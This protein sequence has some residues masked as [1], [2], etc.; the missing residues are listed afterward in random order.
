MFT[1]GNFGGVEFVPPQIQVRGAGE[2]G[3]RLSP[4]VD[5]LARYNDVVPIV[6]G[7]AWYEPPLVF[8]RNDGNLTV[9]EVLLGMGE[10]DEAVKVVVNDIEIPEGVAGADMTATGWYSVVTPGSRS[11]AFNPDFRDGSGNPLGDPYGSMA[12]ASVVVPNRI[13]SGQTVPRIKVLARGVKLERFDVAGASLGETYANN[14]AWVLLD[15]LRRSG[16]LVSEIDTKSFATTAAYCDELISTTDLYGNSIVVPRFQCNTVIRNRT[17]AGAVVRGIRAGSALQLIYGADGLLKLRVENTIAL[18][19]AEKP[20]GS[21]STDEL[22]GGWPA[23]EFSDGS[24]TFSG[25]LRKS[26][27]EPSIRLY[28]RGP[29]DAP[30]RVTV[31]FQDQFN[32]YQQDSLSLVDV[33]DALLTNQEVSGGFQALGIPNYDQATRMLE[34]QLAKSI[35]GSTFIDLETTVRGVELK[36][37]DIITLTYLKEGLDRQALRIVRLV[38]ATNYASVLITAQWHNDAW[39]TSEGADAHGGR[40]RGRSEIGIPR[41]LKGTV[42]DS[43]GNEQFGIVEEA[44][45]TSDGGLSVELNVSFTPPATPSAIASSIPLVSLNPTISSTGGSLQGGVNWYYAVSARDAAGGET[46]L[47]FS[48]KAKIPTAT[49]TNTVTLTGL[50]FSADAVGMNVY[51]GLNPTQF[52]LVS[53]N[54]AVSSTFTDTGLTSELKSPPDGNYDHAVF[55]WRLELQPEV[56][57]TFHSE[58]TI[59]SS[60]LAMLVNE[61]QGAL[62]TITRG[63]GARQERVVVS[64]TTTT[65]TVTPAWLIEPDA[66]SFFVVNENT[67]NAGGESIL[68]PVKLA[69]PPRPGATVQI[70]GRSAN[71]LKQESTYELNPLTR[72]EIGTTLTGID[73][74]IPPPPVYGL[75]P[76]GNGSIS[77]SSLGFTSFTNTRTIDAGTLVL[78]YW[79]ELLSPSTF[80]LNADVDSAATILDLSSA[81]PAITGI[82]LQIG[83][84]ILEVVDPLSGG[85]QYEVIRGSHGSTAAMHLAGSVIYHLKRTIRVLPFPRGFFGSPAS[86][87][88]S[89]AMFLPDVRV[90]ASELFMTNQFGDGL[91]TQAAYTAT[92]D[93]GIRTLSGGQ[94]S[95]DIEG[96]LAVQTAAA[97]AISVDANHSVRD[98]FA[99]VAEAPVGG[100]IEL[101][102]RQDATVYCTL[103][104]PEHATVSTP[105]VD[106]FGLAPLAEGVQLIL[107]ITAVPGVAN[108]LPGRDLTVTIRF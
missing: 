33:D 19:Q 97:P 41:P 93:Q 73:S 43:N 92:T 64:N 105:S 96:Y 38:P 45:P 101:S 99:Q 72:W 47:S 83:A 69:A 89:Q 87:S 53:D 102:I 56:S 35:A 84:E 63:T 79:D 85:T 22:N 21:N 39:Y 15:A 66:T 100:P 78:F 11:G 58:T 34:L 32:E 10:M 26:S 44:V 81:G 76:V 18:Q 90:G 5:N 88:Y 24:A 30:N 37:G 14:P 77:L 67:W 28:S 1:I 65:F 80:S 36:P 23:Y 20:A 7:T 107:D 94:F 42:L 3:Y 60:I 61:F 13:A 17:S 9:M 52:S 55:Y 16:W 59:G 48:V 50:S 86:G 98:I 91:L 95:I 70:S 108:T 74:G 103:T 54:Q 68:G 12:V 29:G 104:I 31:E 49:N 82:L 51:R 75:A 106:G 8:S 40:R 71:V 46:D 2:A 6:Y 62:V 4:V 27:G 57:A 25:I